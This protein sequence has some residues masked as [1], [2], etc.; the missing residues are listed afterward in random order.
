[1]TLANHNKN[2]AITTI[3]Q[4]HGLDANRGKKVVGLLDLALYS[5]SL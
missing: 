2:Q 5:C 4:M 1:M 3:N